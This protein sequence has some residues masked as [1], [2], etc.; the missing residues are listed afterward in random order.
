MVATMILPVHQTTYI[1]IFFILLD[2]TEHVVL[3][4]SGSQQTPYG[5]N[6]AVRRL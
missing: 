1:F 6:Y 5:H 4:I 3:L 2:T